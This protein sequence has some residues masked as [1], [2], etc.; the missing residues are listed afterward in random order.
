[1][2]LLLQHVIVVDDDIEGCT[3]FN[4][5][6]EEPRSTEDCGGNIKIVSN[7]SRNDA[8]LRG[9]ATICYSS[10][11]TGLPKG[12]QQSHFIYIANVAELR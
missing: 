3:S 1:M 5:L 7:S 11:T 10:G 4:S 12:C 9:V 8:S 6:L 2:I